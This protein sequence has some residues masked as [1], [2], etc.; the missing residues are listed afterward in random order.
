MGY[1]CESTPKFLHFGLAA[2]AYLLFAAALASAALVWFDPNDAW[3]RLERGALH[4]EQQQYDEAVEEYSKAI[5]ANPDFTDAYLG[6]CEAYRL[7][8]EN[9][10]ALVDC[11]KALALDDTSAW[12]FAE[13]AELRRLT[14][15][16]KLALADCDRAIELES[17]FAWAYTVRG[18]I[19]SDNGNGGEA[20]ADFNSALWLDPE[21]AMT[22]HLLALELTYCEDEQYQN[23]EEAIFH[24]R[25][26]CALTGWTDPHMVATLAAAYAADG[27]YA[28]A[29]TN[30]RHALEDAPTDELQDFQERLNEYEGAR[31]HLPDL[32]RLLDQSYKFNDQRNQFRTSRP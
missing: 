29:I 23:S 24:A 32:K 22:H 7:L 21:H 1:I 18:S 10:K 5:D 6:R 8:G 17:N 28:K 16:L 20:I 14:G 4:F 30:Q 11:E 9:E 3:V 2:V 31:G 26:S 19:H 27:Q 15:D 25:E 12:G 13:R